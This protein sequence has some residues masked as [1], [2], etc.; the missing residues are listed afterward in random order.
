[1]QSTLENHWP[2]SLSLPDR[3]Y[4]TDEQRASFYQRLEAR[5]GAIGAI[6]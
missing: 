6:R 5:L 2:R 4:P 1:M 3:K